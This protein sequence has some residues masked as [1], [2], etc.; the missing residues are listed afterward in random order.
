MPQAHRCLR[1]GARRAPRRARG[2]PARVGET[3]CSGRRRARA[4]AL[5][6]AA[7]R[8]YVCESIEEISPSDLEAVIGATGGGEGARALFRLLPQ[9]RR[10]GLCGRPSYQHSPTQ[11]HHFEHGGPIGSASRSPPRVQIALCLPPP[12]TSPIP[13]HPSGWHKP[14][15]LRGAT[16]DVVYGLWMKPSSFWTTR[17]PMDK[18]VS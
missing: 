4:G 10:F 13:P 8:V 15:H 6:I 11:L 18:H 17:S 5:L 3:S 14:R 1:A 16:H 12:R 2:S 9:P 7:P